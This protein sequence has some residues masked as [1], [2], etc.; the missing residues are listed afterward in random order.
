[1]TLTTLFAYADRCRVELSGV[2]TAHPELVHKE[3]TTTSRFNTIAKLL[4]HS[5]AAEERWQS[6]I[7]ETPL[8]APYEDR[9][10]E[11]LTALLED[12][13]ARR[14]TTKALLAN[15]T[16]ESLAKIHEINLR[17]RTVSLSNDE[18]FFTIYNHENWHRAQIITALQGFGIEPPDFDYVLLKP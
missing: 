8:P 15:Q 11:S 3:F 9:A 17:G 12:A 6:R 13:E 10:P 2:L 14:E 5:T 4:A 16:Q 7:A 1:M 18:C